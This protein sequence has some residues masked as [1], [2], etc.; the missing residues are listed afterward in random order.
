MSLAE[1]L[2]DEAQDVERLQ[3]AGYLGGRAMS[4]ASGV[5]SIEVFPPPEHTARGRQ[6]LAIAVSA[7]LA[8]RSY[9]IL[10]DPPKTFASGP[11]QQEMIYDFEKAETIRVDTQR[12][13]SLS[14]MAQLLDAV[15][16]PTERASV[17]LTVNP[18]DFPLF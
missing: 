16:R 7:N 17:P 2:L 1:M 13:L 5:L 8:L 4:P 10:M 12:V 6:S 14:E 15:S 3:L 18:D 9:L 11:T